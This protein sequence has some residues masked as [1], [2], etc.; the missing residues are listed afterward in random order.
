MLLVNLLGRK[1]NWHW[2]TTTSTKYTDKTWANASRRALNDFTSWLD[3]ASLTIDNYIKDESL[4]SFYYELW[5]GS[6]PFRKMTPSSSPGIEPIS[7]PPTALSSSSRQNYNIPRRNP[8]PNPST[9]KQLPKL[10]RE[11]S[12]SGRLKD[13]KQQ[14]RKEENLKKR[15]AEFFSNR[16]EKKP[17]SEGIDGNVE[18]AESSEQEV[19]PRAR[20][21][22]RMLK[23][24]GRQGN[25]I[26]NSDMPS[27]LVKSRSF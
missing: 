3:F 7:P 2:K 18:E 25:P 19:E 21:T 17:R 6:T 12:K 5:Y 26:T 27:R 24:L 22:E 10:Y 9:G 15:K 13:K 8:L 16:R 20:V 1:G 4:R 11:Q 14:S 23:T